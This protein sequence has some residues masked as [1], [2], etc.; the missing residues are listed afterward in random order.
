MWEWAKTG[1]GPDVLKV[2]DIFARKEGYGHTGRLG[3]SPDD[4]EIPEGEDGVVP[5]GD[6][7]R[8]GLPEARQLMYRL[9]SACLSDGDWRAFLSGEYR[10]SPCLNQEQQQFCDA[11]LAGKQRPGEWGQFLES[12]PGTGK[13]IC[14][15][16]IAAEFLRRYGR[17]LCKVVVL[18][19]AV[20]RDAMSRCPAVVE[21]RG[22]G[23][24]FGVF[25]DWCAPGLSIPDGY[26]PA[27][28]DEEYPIF[29]DL[30]RKRG[31][32]DV[33]PRDADLYAAF[34]LGGGSDRKNIE[35]AADADRIGEL[36]RKV[37]RDAFHA[38]L[39]KARLIGRIDALGHLDLER[40]A[41]LPGVNRAFVV[42]D[43]A[44]DLLLPQLD[45]VRKVTEDWRKRGINLSVLI[46]AD[47]N[48]RLRPTGFRP[49][50]GLGHVPAAAGLRRNFRNSRRILTFAQRFLKGAE[51][52]RAAHDTRHSPSLA[53]PAECAEVGDPVRI[54]V[55]PG[56]E[57]VLDFFRRL[58]ARASAEGESPRWLIE[59]ASADTK[60]LSQQDT[61]L[62]NG[63]CLLNPA[64]TK[65]LEY[66]ACVVWLRPDASPSY[67][68]V[69][70]WYTLLTRAQSRLLLVMTRSEYADYA[71]QIPERA[72]RK[73]LADC[74]ASGLAE[75]CIDWI[76]EQNSEARFEE[77]DAGQVGRILRE[78]CRAARPYFDTYQALDA[79]RLPPSD[80]EQDVLSDLASRPECAGDCLREGV[81]VRLR[82]LVLRAHGRSWEAAALAAGLTDGKERDR[83]LEAVA[84]DLR[85]GR[86]LHRP[87]PAEADRILAAYSATGGRAEPQL[88]GRHTLPY[89]RLL[90]LRQRL[91]T[92]GRTT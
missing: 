89:V 77:M 16:E 20:V 24:F 65:G 82:C 44:Q 12:G 7:V 38:A 69:H 4:A 11:L 13:T 36:E 53:D 46:L 54:L 18:V 3:N 50:E 29:D 23:F 64:A 10:L 28:R 91:R 19:P 87:L 71:R 34:V 67:T 32:K 60:V 45:V 26:R 8:D 55:V 17:R 42:V 72:E 27:S 43:E 63:V 40:F 47:R 25:E 30:A 92:A 76:R 21:C 31:V 73:S 39:R 58:G 14:A 9:P 2:V 41:P 78:A 90:Q 75:A 84:A 1:E 62:P 81:C 86:G 35:Y 83:L 56:R 15:V 59:R 22:D 88:A 80:F 37:G 49:P 85:L 70:E 68:A 66:A 6:P 51:K 48:Q 79:L 5:P 52:L 33:V 74:W 57:D 61:D